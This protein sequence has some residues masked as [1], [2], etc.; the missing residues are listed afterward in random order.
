MTVVR[1]GCSFMETSGLASVEDYGSI[2]AKKNTVFENQFQRPRQD[3]LLDVAPRLRQVLWRVRV[4]HR[5]DLLNDD[6]S[7]IEPFGDKVRRGADDLDTPLE[8]LVI[9]PR[10]G[11]RR[12]ERVVDIDDAGREPGH[13][14]AAQDPHIFRQ[15]DEF[16]FIRSD[17]FEQPVLVRL[18]RPA[19]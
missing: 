5:D 14:T 16:R 1:K 18:P 10:A 6:G 8:G 7:S 11:K 2:A 3:K 12:K 17:L 15:N 9:R 13:K 4:V 19:F